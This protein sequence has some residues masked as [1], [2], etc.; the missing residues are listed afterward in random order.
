MVELNV[1]GPSAQS[2]QVGDKATFTI[3]VSGG[4][5]PY[6]IEWLK[7]GK[8]IE[9]APNRT[10]FTIS[11]VV[12]SD[13]GKYSANVSDPGGAKG[14]SAKAQLT[15]EDATDTPLLWDQTFA[16][17]A[18]TVLAIVFGIVMLPTWIGMAH[19]FP[20]KGEEL[21]FAGVIAAQTVVVGTL[22]LFGGIYLALLDFRGRS[23]T[24]KE[25]DELGGGRLRIFGPGDE[26]AKAAPAIIKAFGELKAPAAAMAAGIA[27]FICA[28]AVAWKAVPDN[29]TSP[30]G[31]SGS[32]G[33]SGASGPAGTSGPSGTS[34]ATG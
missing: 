1:E 11:K 31:P 25:L 20:P 23:R 22:I 3:K 18:A 7:D 21:H 9:S 5:E 17:S 30:S 24:K 13:Q 33:P 2:V 28:A 10:I 12:G 6:T 16:I 34:G 19:V 26:L 8:K 29:N 32:S 27:L 4:T 14:V 15:V